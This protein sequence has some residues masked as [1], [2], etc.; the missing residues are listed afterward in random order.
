MFFWLLQHIEPN[1]H[2]VTE[3]VTF[4]LIKLLHVRTNNQVTY[5]FTEALF[6]PRFSGQDGIKV[7]LFHISRENIKIYEKLVQYG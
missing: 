3:H 1:C 2:E 7:Y 4:G 6:S 5:I